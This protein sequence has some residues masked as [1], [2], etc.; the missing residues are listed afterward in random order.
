MGEPPLGSKARRS[1]AL[2]PDKTR[3]IDPLRPMREKVR[4]YYSGWRLGAFVV[5]SFWIGDLIGL[6]SICCE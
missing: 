2:H 5:G 3:L 4:N 6:R 1:L